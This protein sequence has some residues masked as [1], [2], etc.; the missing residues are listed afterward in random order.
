VITATSKV[1]YDAESV[2]TTIRILTV[3]PDE[4]RELRVPNAGKRRTIS[5]YFD[6]PQRFAESLEELS[7][8]FEG[9]YLT[10]N[11][12]N[13][14]LL[15]RSSNRCQPFAKT[16]SNDDDVV[17]RKWMLI[18]LDAIRPAGISSSDEEKLEAKRVVG[19][20]KKY[21]KLEKWPDPVT[22][23]SGNGYHLLY[24]IDLPNDDESRDLIKG[25]LAALAA[26]FD[27]TL[28]HVDKSVHNASR[29]VKAYGTKAC[30]GSAVVCP[31]A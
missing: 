2:E 1:S 8:E 19:A 7:G 27:N 4:V 16:T 24:R 23:D 25:V 29:I 21:L 14:A 26:K 10:L 28:V 13:P 18:D 6:N 30:K 15:A 9:V 31:N 11:P 22:C 5:G 3:D 12:V 17:S 20:I